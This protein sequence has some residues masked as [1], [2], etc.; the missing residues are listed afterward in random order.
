MTI[1]RAAFVVAAAVALSGCGHREITTLEREEAANMVSEADFA[2]TIREWSRAEGLYS[3]AVALC[4]D[5]ADTWVSLGIARMRLGDHGGARQAFKSA[6]SA[7]RDDS[8]EHP[9]HSQSVLRRAYV[10]VLLGRAD[11]ARS[12]VGKAHEKY[13]D[14]R[15]LS[16]FIDNGTL[17][18]LVADPA[19]KDISP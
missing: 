10:L 13:P 19:L 11:E 17:D 18:K 15:L 2:T 5:A 14:D 12:V 6:V 1:A 4:P 3:Q 16:E 9:S 7:Y 8:E